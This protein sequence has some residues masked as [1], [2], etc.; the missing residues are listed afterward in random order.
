MAEISLI[1]T[2]A[3][4]ATKKPISFE[5]DGRTFKFKPGK[6]GAMIAAI[7]DGGA[8]ALR[9][10]FDWFWFGLDEADEKFLKERL[11]DLNDPLDN[12]HI[13]QLVNRLWGAVS[14][15][16]TESSSGL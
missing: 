2:A 14:G 5:L 12:D 4:R 16:P 3:K 13:M 10:Q 8:E 15:R 7:A 6:T 1:T 9:S 11:R